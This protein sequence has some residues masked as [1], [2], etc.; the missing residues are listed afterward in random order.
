MFDEIN[1][2]GNKNKCDG[3]GKDFKSGERIMLARANNL[4]FCNASPNSC[5]ASWVFK[6]GKTV[7][8]ETAIFQGKAEKLP[9]YGGL[10]TGCDGCEKE[11]RFGDEIWVD[12]SLQLIFCYSEDATCIQRWKEQPE[13]IIL[14]KKMR[15]HGNT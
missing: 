15:F 7:M 3:C 11:F 12:M 5:I 13:T 6:N 14:P 8:A 2:T 10:K 9:E 4:I 1:Y